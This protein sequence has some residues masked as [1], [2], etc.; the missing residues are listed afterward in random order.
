VRES[1][2]LV[3]ITRRSGEDYA[4]VSYPVFQ[5]LRRERGIPSD[6]AAYAPLPVSIAGGDDPAPIVRMAINTTGNYFD[7]LGV[8]PAVGRFFASSESFYPA[9]APE[10]VISG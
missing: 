7:V 3:E 8:R 9:V 10:V 1:D 6:A 5:A 2:R 4:D